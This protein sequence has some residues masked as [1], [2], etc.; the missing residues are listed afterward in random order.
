[1]KKDFIFAPVMLL[2]GA[3]LFFLSATG[4]TAHIV[5]SFVGVLVLAVYTV[6]TKKDWKHPALEIITRACYGIALVSG[7]VIKMVHGITVLSITHKVSAVL[8]MVF[9]IV[10]LAQKVSS[11]KKA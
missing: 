1:M 10:S 6:L 2:I 9:V 5:I 11:N 3:L 7:I 8:F 4:M